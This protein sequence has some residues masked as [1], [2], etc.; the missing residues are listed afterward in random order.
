MLEE[1]LIYLISMAFYRLNS[2][3][4]SYSKG[5]GRLFLK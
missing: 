3:L 1:V 4:N 5:K 2:I